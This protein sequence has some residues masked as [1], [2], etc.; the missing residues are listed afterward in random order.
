MADT[1]SRPPGTSHTA[2]PYSRSH[3]TG[4]DSCSHTAGPDS[5]YEEQIA[6][7]NNLSS[8]RPI[9][10]IPPATSAKV[11]LVVMAAAQPGSWHLRSQGAGKRCCCSAQP[12]STL[13]L[14]V[15]QVC[16]SSATSCR[17][18]PGWW[19]PNA[20]GGRFSPPYKGG[21]PGSEGD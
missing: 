12:P 13:Y 14:R 4:L 2:R 18:S 7:L 3:T 16:S 8:G 20:T 5:W 10:A 6:G 1:L 9:A 15:L 11:D 19:C 21:T 17:G